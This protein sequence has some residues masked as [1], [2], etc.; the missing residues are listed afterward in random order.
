MTLGIFIFY[1]LF[2]R[3]NTYYD[4]TSNIELTNYLK[5]FMITSFR[6]VLARAVFFYMPI[7]ILM[8]WV[9][10]NR[11]QLSVFEKQIFSFSGV[12]LSV[13][14]FFR[15]LLNYNHESLQISQII[16]NPILTI[17]L[18][19]IFTILVKNKFF[20]K[21]YKRWIYVLIIIH[22]SSS[23]YVLLNKYTQRE[24][25]GSLDFLNRME[26]ELKELSPLGVFIR[27]SAETDFHSVSP[28]L[29]HFAEPLKLIGKNKWV[30]S[31]SVPENLEDFPFPER[32]SSIA[33]AP[34]FKF[35]QDQKKRGVYISYSNAQ[36]EFI[37]INNIDFVLI[38]EGVTLSKEL[39]SII[40]KII[41]D[42]SSGI[43]LGIFKNKK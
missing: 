16:F 13:T 30:N 40:E 23:T 3:Y 12:L 35:I 42:E 18:L 43:R 9:W 28:H 24:H 15:G 32:I 2:G 31:I 21:K 36:K 38:E 27:F 22:L 19:F 14:I 33:D 7:I 8:S 10:M 1:F 4:A 29:C 39:K 34:F 5:E 41:T 17:L 6:D 25:I 26:I 37:E 11:S 20:I